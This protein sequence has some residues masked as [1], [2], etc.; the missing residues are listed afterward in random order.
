MRSMNYVTELSNV[1][2]D[3][4]VNDDDKQAVLKS[5]RDLADKG[6]PEARNA[7]DTGLR[8]P[9]SPLQGKVE[10]LSFAAVFDFCCKA[11][12]S[13]Q[14]FEFWNRWWAVPDVIGGLDTTDT[15]SAPRPSLPPSYVDAGVLYSYCKSRGM[16]VQECHVF[17]GK[18]GEHPTLYHRLAPVNA[19]VGLFQTIAG[20][21]SSWSG[22]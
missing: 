10:S 8:I 21:F 3:S 18:L 15:V 6:D 9:L 22:F 5:L 16:S 1:L 19:R 17:L 7:L 13:E 14:A 20:F 2:R 12:W 11:G 4:N